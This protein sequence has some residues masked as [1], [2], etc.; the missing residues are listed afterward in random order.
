MRIKYPEHLKKEISG[1]LFA[2]W[3]FTSYQKKY[4]FLSED[5]KISY[6]CENIYL[7]GY[8]FLNLKIVIR[9]SML[10]K[11]KQVTFVYD[12][13][14]NHIDCD[15]QFSE[16][17]YKEIITDYLNI[18]ITKTVPCKSINAKRYI[19][20]GMKKSTFFNMKEESYGFLNIRYKVNGSLSNN[21]KNRRYFYIGRFCENNIIIAHPKNNSNKAFVSNVF[22]S[23]IY[24]IKMA[25]EKNRLDRN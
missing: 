1:Q 20:D 21:N 16:E 22:N 14:N 23:M 15:S 2:L 4:T 25:G 9:N 8:R 11:D 19:M 24:Y 12:L 3:A 5:K 6:T 18:F 10:G 7:F 13:K 17:Y